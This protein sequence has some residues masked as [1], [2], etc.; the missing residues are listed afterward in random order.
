MT[1]IDRTVAELELK[2]GRNL[3][4]SEREIVIKEFARNRLSGVSLKKARKKVRRLILHLLHFP[5]SD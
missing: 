2:L 4:D 5:I 1:I 3:G